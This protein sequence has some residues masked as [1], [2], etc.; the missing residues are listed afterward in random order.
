MVTLKGYT[1]DILGQST[2]AKPTT[3]VDTNTKFRELDTG[4]RYYFNGSAWAEIPQS[5]GGGDVTSV[6]SKTGA[7]VLDAED[8]GALPASTP[9]P[10]AQV[11][12]DWTASSGVSEILHKPTLGTAA[13][14]N[15]TNAVTESSADLV[16]SG[17]VFTELATKVNK[18]GT[19]RLMTAAEGT[20]LAGIETGATKNT[21]IN[22]TCTLTVAGWT[23]ADV[24]YTQTV[25]VTGI[26]ATDVAICDVSVSSTVATGVDEMDDWELISKI[27]S[28]AGTLTFSCYEDKP[29]T[30]L[31]VNVKVVR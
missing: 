22:T 3:G 30:E 26:L 28:G 24:P 16:E 8:V 20:K 29:I 4:K 19:D 17:A 11:N 14:K 13:R 2:D 6:N 21:V 9:I 5:G 31:N 27:E 7:V 1:A 10:A 18:N 15:S 12:A 23:G 25:N